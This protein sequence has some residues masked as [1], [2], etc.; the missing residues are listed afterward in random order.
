MGFCANACTTDAGLRAY[1]RTAGLARGEIQPEGV[2][3]T[4]LALPVEETLCRRR[5][6][7]W[8][9]AE[10]ER[11]RSLMGADFWTYGLAGNSDTLRTFVRYSF[12]QG[13]VKRQLPVDELFA[14][15]TREEYVI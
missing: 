11:T 7:P 3:L 15:E 10:A 12:G 9:Y 8:G 2:D 1:D 5:A 14:A 6:R 4:F 13:L